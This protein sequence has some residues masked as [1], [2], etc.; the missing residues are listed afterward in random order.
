MWRIS[1]CQADNHVSHN[2]YTK[3][4]LRSL[5]KINRL[6]YP[7]ALRSEIYI[8]IYT[9]HVHIGSRMDESCKDEEKPVHLLVKYKATEKKKKRFTCNMSTEGTMETMEEPLD[10][11]KWL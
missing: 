2:E 4:D 5:Y 6:H 8:Y 11:Q 3:Q 10:R 9:V 7:A 1:Q